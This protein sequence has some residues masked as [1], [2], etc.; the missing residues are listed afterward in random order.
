MHCGVSLTGKV[1][2]RKCP[3]RSSSVL[4][5]ELTLILTNFTRNKHFA[6]KC[7]HEKWMW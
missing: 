7:G 4:T 3:Y 5:N 2:F 1:A 6:S